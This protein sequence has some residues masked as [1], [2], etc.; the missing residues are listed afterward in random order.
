MALSRKGGDLTAH[1]DATL[2]V[3]VVNTALGKTGEATKDLENL[4]DEPYANFENGSALRLRK[5]RTSIRSGHPRAESVRSKYKR[6]PGIKA[7]CCPQG[8]HSRLKSSNEIY[9]RELHFRRSRER[10]GAAESS[11]PARAEKP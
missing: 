2:A 10:E 8:Q 5:T 7:F 1:F 9:R 11:S 4:R 3:A 6:M